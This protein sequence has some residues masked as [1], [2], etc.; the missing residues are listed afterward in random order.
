MGISACQL[1]R[2]PAL[3]FSCSL[4]KKIA[5]GLLR[6]KKWFTF[7]CSQAFFEKGQPPQSEK[8]Q[9]AI[10]SVTKDL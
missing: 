4:P 9:L 8:L 5:I 7:G 1:L 6:T 2:R 10:Y 3:L